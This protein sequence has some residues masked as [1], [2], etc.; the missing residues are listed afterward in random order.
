MCIRSF[1]KSLNKHEHSDKQSVSAKDR[2]IQERDGFVPTWFIICLR[3]SQYANNYRNTY[4]V[5]NLV[6]KTKGK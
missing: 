3:H 2:P 4:S 1:K 6:G 5:I